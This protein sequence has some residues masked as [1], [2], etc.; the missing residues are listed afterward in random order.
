MAFLDDIK[1]AAKSIAM[2]T[3]DMVEVS[4]LNISISQEK[5]KIN[6]LYTEIGREVY[7]QYKAGNDAGFGDKCAVIAEHE[8]TIEEL[9][10][11]IYTLKNIKKCYAC[12]A[13]VGMD[14]AYCPQCGAKQ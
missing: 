9:R 3:G 4:K 10:M 12:G 7:E 1:K 14:S 11:K 5:D 6:K 2:K 8:R 13:E